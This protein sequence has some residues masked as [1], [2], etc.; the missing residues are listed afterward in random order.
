ML[1]DLMLLALLGTLRLL[2]VGQ[3]RPDVFGTATQ[4]Q[5]ARNAH[6]VADRRRVLA[7]VDLLAEQ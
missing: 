3:R 1:L 4:V 6:H 5:P 7:Q 2:V